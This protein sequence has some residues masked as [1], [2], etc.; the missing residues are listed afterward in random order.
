LPSSLIAPALFGLLAALLWG[1]VDFVSRRPSRKIGYYQTAAY[2]QIIGFLALTLYVAAS[3]SEYPILGHYT[4]FLLT[5]NFM[6]RAFN[7]L[8][9]L[10]LYRGFSTGVMS[11]V[12]SISGSYPIVTIALSISF[13]GAVLRPFLA[14]GIAIV[15][16]GIILTGV[17]LTEI[18][19]LTSRAYNNS[20]KSGKLSSD[21]ETLRLVQKKSQNASANRYFEDI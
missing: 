5:V 15:L 17:N 11:I 19:T 6:A 14:I 13:L 12:A 18:R 7:F 20:S 1:T 21:K 4:W 8:G 9:F 16:G 2:V 10:F 3:P